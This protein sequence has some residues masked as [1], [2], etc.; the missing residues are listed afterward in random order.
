[1]ITKK[2]YRGNVSKELDSS[3]W[4]ETAAVRQF[5]VKRA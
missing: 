3:A 4:R 5:G 1:M 2:I